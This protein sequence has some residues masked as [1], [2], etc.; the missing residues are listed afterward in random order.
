[1]GNNKKEQVIRLALAI[2]LA[3]LATVWMLL[4]GLGHEDRPEPAERATEEL[5][6]VPLVYHQ[7]EAEELDVT[8]VA[9]VVERY[10]DICISPNELE[11]LAAIVYLEAG[12]QCA[13]G[14]QAV[15]E[16]ILNRV[17]ADNFPVTVHDVIHE[18]EDNFVPQFS[19]AEYIDTA[20]PEDVVFFALEAEN[21]HVWGQIGDHIFCQEYIWED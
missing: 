20:R 10:R 12:N 17:I 5:E 4:S 19:T 2:G 11:E 8:L 21:D 13:E 18:G 15:A 9:P 1:M 7:P 6:L 3:L 14:Q 16:V